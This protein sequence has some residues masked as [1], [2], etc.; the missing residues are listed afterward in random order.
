LEGFENE[1]SEV[2]LLLSSI[3]V[4]LGSIRTRFFHVYRNKRRRVVGISFGIKIQRRKK[5]LVWGRFWLL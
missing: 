1:Y 4:H 3:R 2:F 5:C